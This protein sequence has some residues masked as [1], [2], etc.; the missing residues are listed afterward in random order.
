MTTTANFL[1]K[2]EANRIEKLKMSICYDVQ[3]KAIEFDI[4]SS[5]VVD[6]KQVYILPDDD[7]D[8]NQI[9]AET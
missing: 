5:G 8:E 4:Q 2:A 3:T 6:K 7:F 1:S 9:W